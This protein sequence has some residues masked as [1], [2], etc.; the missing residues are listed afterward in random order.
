MV[1][2]SFANLKKVLV[3]TGSKLIHRYEARQV[4]NVLIWGAHMIIED[5]HMKQDD[6][7]EAIDE[8]T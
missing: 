5:N 4:S 2:K 1:E 8:P 3:H 7:I 6:L